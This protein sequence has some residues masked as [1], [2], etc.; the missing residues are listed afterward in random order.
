[1]YLQAYQYALEPL[2]GKKIWHEIIE[3]PVHP[4]PFKMMPRRPKVNIKKA[5]DEK[6][7]DPNKLSRNGIRMQC[8]I[9]YAYGHNKRGCPRKDNPPSFKDILENQRSRRRTRC[10]PAPKSNVT[11]IDVPNQTTVGNVE[12]APS[13]SKPPYDKRTVAKERIWMLRERNVRTVSGYTETATAARQSRKRS[14]TQR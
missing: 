11:N 3:A 6:E 9:C 8:R 7:R 2:N 5:V 1:M 14:D 12:A 13:Q 4:P 10:P